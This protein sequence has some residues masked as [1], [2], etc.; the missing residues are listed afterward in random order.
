MLL[1]KKAGDYKILA[2]KSVGKN[3]S[4]EIGF[5]SNFP[6]DQLFLLNKFQHNKKNEEIFKS[7]FVYFSSDIKT[8]NYVDFFSH[9]NYFYA[10]FKYKEE[11]NLKYRYNAKTCI[12]NFEERAR[13][14]ENILI[15]IYNLIE[16]RKTPINILAT[17]L[18]SEC[19]VVDSNKN[20]FFNF[21][22]QF[23]N[24]K[25]NFE[26]KLIF[27]K[28]GNI[29]STMF[30]IESASKYNKILKI[31]IK[32]CDLGIYDSIPK[33]VVEFKKNSEEIK[34]SSF[35]LYW[36]RR[37]LMQKHLIKKL[38]HA[39]LAPT[40]IVAFVYLIYK[41]LTNGDNAA[42]SPKPVTIGEISYSASA[43]DISDKTITL[44]PLIE[45]PAQIGS[46]EKIILPPNAP[47]EYDDYIT[48]YDDT[49]SSICQNFYSETKFESVITSFNNL[50][51]N[52]AILPGIILKIPNKS[53][54][55]LYLEN[56]E[57]VNS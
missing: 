3:S 52:D 26:E 37:F 7:L 22:L 44:H 36:K 2:Q 56:N 31:I 57:H 24:T 25:E 43:Q 49:I 10:V 1:F 18:N 46:T 29:I 20:D 32:K 42:E 50:E 34:I 19:I 17:V 41:K 30:E 39:V 12:A 53:S 33:L 51:K 14:L 13:I 48:R 5:K 45:K 54:M 55:A 23:L 35:W 8:S 21:D 11:Q 27:K 28:I 38:T 4:V 40:L 47:I 16:L 6:P 9:S 15:K